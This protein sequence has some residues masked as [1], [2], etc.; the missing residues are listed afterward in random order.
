MGSGFGY[1]ESSLYL[2]HL[3]CDKYNDFTG[4]IT[5]NCDQY[6]YNLITL[7]VVPLSVVSVVRHG[8]RVVTVSERLRLTNVSGRPLQAQLMAAPETGIKIQPSCFKLESTSLPVN[9]E[10]KQSECACALLNWQLLQEESLSA[11][12]L[13][14]VLYISFRME[15]QSV[16]ST[17]HLWSVPVR[18]ASNN[19]GCRSTVAVVSEDSDVCCMSLCVTCIVEGAQTYVVV[20][21][22]NAPMCWIHNICPFPLQYGQALHKASFK[23]MILF[24]EFIFSLVKTFEIHINVSLHLYISRFYSIFR[25][26]CSWRF[27]LLFLVFTTWTG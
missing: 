2:Q 24:I 14:L 1:I 19:E 9:D 16:S 20:S 27:L 25:E 8:M 10:K 18:I 7:Q 17:P 15:T 21:Q 6:I 11:G 23:G 4:D 26:T 13:E 12:P 22:D 5:V 3:N